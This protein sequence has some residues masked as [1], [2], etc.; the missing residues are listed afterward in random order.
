MDHSDLA[1][2]VTTFLPSDFIEREAASLGIIKRQRRVCLVPLIWTLILGMVSAP[3]SSF[4]SLHRLYVLITAKTLARSSFYERLTPDITALFARLLERMLRSNQRAHSHWLEHHAEDF[5]Q[6]LATDSTVVSLRKALEDTWAACQNGKSALKLHTTVNVLDFKLHRVTFTDQNTH[7]LIGLKTIRRFCNRRLLLFD[8]GYYDFATFHAIDK[9]GGY[10]LTR[11]KSNLS[12]TLLEVFETGSGAHCNLVGM[13]VKHALKRSKRKVIEGVVELS[14]GKG[15]TKRTVR[16]RFV[17][18]RNEEGK[19]H[20][21]LTNLPLSTYPGEEVG[22]LY[23]MRWQVEKM[24]SHLKSDGHL[25]EQPSAKEH[26][27]KLR[28]YAVLLAYGLVGRLCERMRRKHPSGRYPVSRGM[29]TLAMLGQGLLEEISLP[30]RSKER[31]S[32]LDYFEQM[33]RDPNDFRERPEDPLIRC[34]DLRYAA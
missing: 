28:I 3:T 8:L 2:L 9:A 23:R 32:S 25:D 29:R 14:S 17:A 11:A 26:L 6:V 33:T 15:K 20:T 21:Y 5:D 1:R 34:S 4:A 27:V 24:Y 16:C 7:D 30:W 18:V 22:Q 19:Y 31:R 10:F 13:K 12:A